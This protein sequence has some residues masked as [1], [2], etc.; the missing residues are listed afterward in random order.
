MRRRF[1]RTAL[2][3][4]LAA[5]AC[6]IA[7]AQV[8]KSS[9]RAYTPAKTEW[10]DPDNEMIHDARIVGMDGQPHGDVQRW[11]GDSR[12]H[13]DSQTLVVD[14]T[15]FNG[16]APVRG[17]GGNL[18]LIERFTRIDPDT[19]KYE[20]TIDDPT[21]WTRQWTVSFPMHHTDQPMY[22][23]ACHEGNAPSMEGLLRAARV[24]ERDRSR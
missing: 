17:S 2:V 11:M 12:G 21:V 10:G 14:T 7:G 18:H 23:Y 16:K 13:W 9:G 6:A 19:L 24:A 8:P 5:A 1:V 4:G 20:F 22:E 3:L 15:R